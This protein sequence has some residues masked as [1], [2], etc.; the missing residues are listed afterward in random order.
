M[1][2]IYEHSSTVFIYGAML[3]LCLEI[4]D[5]FFQLEVF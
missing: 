3:C 5:M 2:G 4:F 1:S